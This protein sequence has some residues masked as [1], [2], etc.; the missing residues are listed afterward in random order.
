MRKLV[1]LLLICLVALCLGSPATAKTG[2]HDL[3]VNSALDITTVTGVKLPSYFGASDEYYASFKIW[4]VVPGK[5]YEATL[6]YDAGTEIGYA[7]AWIDGDPSTKEAQ[8]FVGIG[9]GTG[10]RVLKE[11][12]EKFLFSV[13]PGSTSNVFYVLVRSHKPWNIRFAVTDS[14]SGV[15]NQ[16][17]DK[18][19]Y[20]YVKDFDADKNAPF[21]LK[22]G[23]VM[24][25]AAEPVSAFQP[26]FWGPFAF[27]TNTMRGTLKIVQFSDSEG[28]AWLNIGG[29]GVEEVLKVVFSGGDIRFTRTVDCRFGQARTISQGFTGNVLPD[30]T[31]QGSYSSSDQP[32]AIHPWQ[33]QR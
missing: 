22:R 12:E 15:T 24:T 20:Y 25:A 16:S 18:W 32:D 27:Q 29:T 31:L 14:P 30:G 9:T 21:L 33:A 26:R 11:K 3:Q 19:G 13:D 28:V 1:T 17:Q 4:P 23:G 10:S 6:T 5:R 7:T 8:S 2:F